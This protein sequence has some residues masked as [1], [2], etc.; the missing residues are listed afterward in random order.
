MRK[1]RRPRRSRSS[2]HWRPRQ[3]GR[4]VRASSR[5]ADVAGADPIERDDPAQRSSAGYGRLVNVDRAA[6]ARSERRSRSIQRSPIPVHVRQA[7]TPIRACT[8][9]THCSCPMRECCSRA[10]TRLPTTKR[11]W[12][13]THPL[14]CSTPIARRPSDRR[15][16]AFWTI[17]GD[18]SPRIQRASSTTAR[19]FRSRHRTRLR[20]D[21]LFSFGPEPRLTHSTW[22]SG[23]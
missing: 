1:S 13:C 16:R 9:Q 22:I 4:A 21:R 23:W 20:S 15:L 5:P 3:R 17:R 18:Q 14:T 11:A 10:A 19:A 12:R 7:P 6:T 2:S 8:T